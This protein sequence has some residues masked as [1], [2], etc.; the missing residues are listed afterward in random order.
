MQFRLDVPSSVM[1]HYLVTHGHSYTICD[2]LTGWGQK[3]QGRLEPISFEQIALSGT[4]QRGAYIFTD[5]ERLDPAHMELARQAWNTLEAAGN[6]VLLNN[7]HQVLRR[8]PML[9][10]LSQTGRNPFSVHGVNEDFKTIRFPAFIRVHN[11]HDGAM[12]ELIHSAADLKESP[13]KIRA[14]GARDEDLLIVEYTDTSDSDGVFRKYGAFRVGDRIIPRHVLLSRKWML[15]YPDLVDEM[16]VEEERRY[17]EENPHE[18]ELRQIFDLARIDY[19]RIDYGVL[20]GRVV[21]WEINT[22][23][24]II[25][26]PERLTE[27]R[28]PLQEIFM[29][30][31]AAALEKLDEGAGGDPI[32]F[33]VSR[34]QL[35]RLSLLKSD[36]ALRA[37]RTRAGKLWSRIRNGK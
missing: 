34:E 12:T 29:T 36:R 8:E 1:I 9:R 4:R 17:L 24:T 27:S 14:E 15:K 7:P 10:V 11:S 6:C 5:L 31:F 16:T 19:G 35:A 20:N 2:Y 23:P 26:P 18:A 22:N 28:K 25:V 30:A 32:P 37:V 3:L 13:K 21:T 33:T